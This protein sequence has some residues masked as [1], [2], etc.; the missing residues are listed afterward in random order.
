MTI[1]NIKQIFPGL[2]A[3]LY[4]EIMEHGDFKEV[5]AGTT[6]LKMGQTIRSTMLVVEGIV[7]LYREDEEGREFFIYNL[8]E[9]QACSLSTVCSIKHEASEILAKAQTDVTLLSI[10]F[11][12]MEEW[13][14]KYKSW[15]QFVLFNYRSRFEELLK[16]VDA[17]AFS[18]MDERLETYLLKQVETMGDEIRMT[19]Q[20][21]A[22]DLN[23]SRE[24]ISR[25][26][27]KMEAKG[28][29]SIGRNSIKW[30]GHQQLSDNDHI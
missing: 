29:V 4:E 16:T 5:T 19:H 27:K 17:I 14:G 21:I 9:G 6:L 18:N 26:L 7:K 11:R 22:N 3:D 2:E 20:E 1:E 10:P 25:L 30:L 13:M 24:V 23:S 8:S 15:Y 12:N 28:W